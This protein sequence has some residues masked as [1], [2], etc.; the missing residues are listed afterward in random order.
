MK[1]V[2]RRYWHS[3]ITMVAGFVL[4]FT[5]MGFSL[6]GF[7]AAKVDTAD[8]YVPDAGIT[9]KAQATTKANELTVEIAEEGMTLLKN[10]ANALPLAKNSKVSLFGKN[11]KRPVLGG[12]GSSG[13]AGGANAQT[14]PSSLTDAGFSVNPALVTFYGDDNASG[15]CRDFNVTDGGTATYYGLPVDETEA[16]KYT[17]TIKGSFADYS[18]AALIFLSRVGGEAFDL[19]RTSYPQSSTSGIMRGRTSASEHYLQ[20]DKNEEDL[21]KMVKASGF[22]KIILLLNTGTSFEL[23]FVDTAELGVDAVLHVGYP[24]GQGMKALGKILCGDVNPSGKTVDIFSKDFKK[25]PVWQNFGNNLVQNGNRYRNAAGATQEQATVAYREG[26]YLGYRYYETRAFT[27]QAFKYWDNVQY[28]FGYGQSYTKFDWTVNGTGG[29][30]TADSV[31][32]LHVTVKNTG[33]VKGKDVVQVYYN[34]PYTAGGIEKAHVVLAAFDKTKLLDPGA[35]DTLLLS[36][37]AKQMASWNMATG[38]YVLEAGTYNIFVGRDSHDCWAAAKVNKISFTVAAD[39]VFDKSS[40]G[41]DYKNVFGEAGTANIDMFNKAVGADKILSRS[42][43]VGTWPKVFG[44]SAN[45]AELAVTANWSSGNGLPSSG[46][47]DTTILPKTGVTPAG[48]RIMLGDMYG[49][50]KD[51]AKWEEFLDQF[52]IAQMSGITSGGFAMGNPTNGL[53]GFGYYNGECPDGPTGFVAHGSHGPHGAL[54]ATNTCFYASPH[55]V[56][57]TYNQ[58]LARRQGDAIG[59][60]GLLGGY[61]GLYA[62]AM[63]SH[64]SPFSGRNFEY[65]SEDPLLS[66]KIGAA[67]IRGMQSKGC[68]AFMKHF[69]LNDQETN[70]D[71]PN[72]LVTWA[73]EQTIREVYAETWRYAVEE[74]GALG[75]MSA[76]NRI[77]TTWAGQHWGALNELLRGE[78][79]FRGAV[80]TD[81]SQGYM[82]SDNMIRGGGD[83]ILDSGKAGTGTTATHVAALRR[84]MHNISC[85]RANSM[86]SIGYQGVDGLNINIEKGK[87]VSVSLKPT[88][89]VFRT[90]ALATITA[91]YSVAGDLG[92]LSFDTA[93]GALTGTAPATAGALGGKITVTATEGST[94]MATNVFSI[95]VFEVPIVTP[96][97]AVAVSD[98]ANDP[99]PP[100]YV[101][102]V[103]V[104]GAPGAPTNFSA[105]P[106]NGQVALSWGAPSN[107]GASAI[108]KYQVSSD[109]GSTWVDASSTTGHTFTGLTG[110]TQYNFRVRAVNAEGNG[111]AAVASATPTGGPEQ[112][113][114]PSAP[115]SFAA[116]GGDKKVDLSWKAP[117]TNAS[118]ITKYEVSSDNGGTWKDAGNALKY[119][120]TGLENGKEYTFKVR[121]VNAAG[122]GAEASKAETPGSKGGCACGTVGDLG[123]MMFGGGLLLIAL[124]GLYLA[125]SVHG[126]R[127]ALKEV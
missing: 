97:A 59:N 125:T 11:T 87:P 12:S 84:A 82:N 117:A 104:S 75:C 43:W 25:D 38:K 94:R 85:M 88:R 105:T 1:K 60:E 6:S 22:G 74:G 73:N 17:D 56:A 2:F 26:I 90:G 89:T 32:N 68:V 53:D 63:N 18:D 108:T 33:A 83:M 49:L 4:V 40:T 31:I 58:E 9:S 47:W 127:K 5:G 62:P 79:G 39:I 71:N 118:G 45:T 23:G 28:P 110:G 42:D 64:R 13:G 65:Y 37:P 121:A 46:P 54:S 101:P 103:V 102:E 24:G 99:K 78:W 109:N 7:S 115:L 8:A 61:A 119:T 66:G 29:A 112:L 30:L 98:G 10:A 111:A 124:G 14:V 15:K 69:F 27:D 50:A 52:S 20:L 51:D 100:E 123:S 34:P 21:I 91:T 80:V 126:K 57:Q 106:G 81:W 120:F 122:A 77:G 92:G 16:A 67:V 86:V 113:G 44:G 36:F 95:N 107:T 114:T 35:E 48:G 93:T 72:S 70:R 55:L 19:P 116:K 96:G 41:K 3:L 76:F